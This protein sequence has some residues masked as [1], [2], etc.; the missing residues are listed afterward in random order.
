M[1]YIVSFYPDGHLLPDNIQDLD[2]SPL[3]MAVACWGLRCNK[4]LTTEVVS[5]EFR[6]T[7]QR[8][9]DALHYIRHEAR[10]RITTECIVMT[11]PGL[12][13]TITCKGLRVLGVNI[14]ALDAIR[15]RPRAAPD[16]GKHL[17]RLASQTTPLHQLRRWMV[18]RRTGEPVPG[19]LLE[20]V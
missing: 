6:I 10:D 19:S 13:R 7:Q 8:A 5:R 18:S 12:R 9:R 4:I 11:V 15:E 1:T 20:G 16:K 2:H 3:Y 17:Q 14:S